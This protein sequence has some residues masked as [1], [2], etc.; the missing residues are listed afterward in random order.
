MQIGSIV[1]WKYSKDRLFIVVTKV[2]NPFMNGIS[3]G[4]KSVNSGKYFNMFVSDLEVIC[5]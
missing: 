3:V 1:K 5:K 4:V 2:K